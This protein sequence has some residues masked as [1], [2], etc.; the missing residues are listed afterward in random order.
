MGITSSPQMVSGGSQGAGSRQG[1]TGGLE[2]E[3]RR[4]MGSGDGLVSGAKQL[5][6]GKFE[7]NTPATNREAGGGIGVLEAVA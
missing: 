4:L 6:F 2:E 1:N 3:R 5:L 7:S